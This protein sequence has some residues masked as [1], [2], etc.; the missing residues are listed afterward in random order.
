MHSL[1]TQE[2]SFKIKLEEKSLTMKSVLMVG[3]KKMEPNIGLSEIHGEA[4]GVK[5]E[6]SESSE[7]LTT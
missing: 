2:E 5:E 6:M 4:T 3:V 1:T 7:V